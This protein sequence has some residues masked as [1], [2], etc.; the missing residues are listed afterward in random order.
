MCLLYETVQI[1]PADLVA[2]R[3]LISL[4][5]L[6]TLR[7]MIIWCKDSGINW[8]I[9]EE[10]RDFLRALRMVVQTG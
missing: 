9:K 2:V 8:D 1:V 3:S 6:R 4:E 10:G 5:S 7:E